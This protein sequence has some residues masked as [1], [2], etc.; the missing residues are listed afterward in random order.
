MACEVYKVS[1]IMEILDISKNVA[2]D[3]VKQAVFPVITIKSTFRIPKKS[4]EDWMNRTN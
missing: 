2:Y 1:D 4:F 3:L